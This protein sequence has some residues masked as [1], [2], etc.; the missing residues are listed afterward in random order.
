MV[1]YKGIRIYQVALLAA[2]GLSTKSIAEALGVGVRT[3]NAHFY[4][5]FIRFG[6]KN[7]L[8]LINRLMDQGDIL[9]EN[10]QYYLSKTIP[11]AD[12]FPGHTL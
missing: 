1:D 2:R 4:N 3:V 7:R 6:A 9:V 10:G 5:G 8:G 11:G 12:E